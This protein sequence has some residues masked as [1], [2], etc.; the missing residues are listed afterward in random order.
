VTIETFFDKA[1]TE[2]KYLTGL[3]QGK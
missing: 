3:F 2:I 1:D